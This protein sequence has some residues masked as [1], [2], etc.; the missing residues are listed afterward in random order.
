MMTSLLVVS[1]LQCAP[2]MRWAPP[3]VSRC[4]QTDLVQRDHDGREQ[5][6]VRFSPRCMQSRCDNGDLV[7][8]TLDGLELV[9]VAYASNCAVQRCE[10][11]DLVVRDLAGRE[12][13][14]LAFAPRC[15]PPVPAPR[16]EPAAWTYGLT[17]RR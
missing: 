9:R 7:R 16:P 8:S 1:L 4:E 3:P 13:E 11:G 15:L 2:V 12:L 17:A 10:R 5:G 14:R 6:R